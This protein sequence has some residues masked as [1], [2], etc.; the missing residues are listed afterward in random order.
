MKPFK[1]CFVAVLS[2]LP[3]I[4]MNAQTTP[5][6]LL[7][8]FPPIPN[9][10]CS[11][12][13]SEVNRFTSRIY[14][15]KSAL[16]QVI[17]RIHTE[18]QA[19][20]EKLKEKAISQVAH[21]SGL[22]EKEIEQLQQEN[23]TE[24]HALKAANKVIGEQY[25]LSLQELEKV[26]EMS[27]ADQEKWAQNYANQ[28]MQRAKQNPQETLKN[29][30]K[31]ARLFELAK[32]QKAIGERITEKMAK[33]DKLFRYIEQQDTIE[34]RKLH[35][36]LQPL[37]KQLC[38]GICSPAEI[39]RSRAAEKQIYSLKLQHCEKMSPLQIDAI[40]QYLTTVKT[41][42]PDYRRLTEVQNEI[43]KLQFGVITPDDLSCY[44][45]VDEYADVLSSAYNYWV[46]KFE[47]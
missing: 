20:E 13:S 17:D 46:G 1:I 38:S 24:E 42:F 10:V 47:K 40:T 35:E 8:Q 31:N 6:A 43:V 2:L 21:Q 32:E 5:E 28:Q 25:N 15:V 37:E 14:E 33:V 34:T 9:V 7:N 36:K 22:N 19:N 3:A 30:R 39:A 16:Q 29:Q 4:I 11:A 41:L 45:A 44:K 27:D 23:T 12:D 18:A 26:G